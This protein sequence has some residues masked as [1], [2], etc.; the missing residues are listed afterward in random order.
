VNSTA[1]KPEDRK[2]LTEEDEIKERLR[3]R[4]KI[5]EKEEPVR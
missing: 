5:S 4:V 1:S 2:V 3:A